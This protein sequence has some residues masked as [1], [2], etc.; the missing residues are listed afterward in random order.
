MDIETTRWTATDQL[1]SDAAVLAYLE[2]ASR[3]AT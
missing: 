1:D 3:T 2:A